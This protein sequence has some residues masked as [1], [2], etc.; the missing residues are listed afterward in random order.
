MNFNGETNNYFFDLHIYLVN[1]I[2]EISLKRIRA[3]DNETNIL[4]P[5]DMNNVSFS[6][7]C[8]TPIEHHPIYTRYKVLD[9]L[10]DATFLTW[11]ITAEVAKIARERALKYKEEKQEDMLRSIENFAIYSKN[12]DKTLNDIDNLR[13]KKANE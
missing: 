10:G 6:Q 3:I 12:V 2:G 11:E 8:Y 13:G 7:L 1:G 9:D 5:Y 4:I